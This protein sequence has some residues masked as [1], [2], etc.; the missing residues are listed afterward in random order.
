MEM[1]LTNFEANRRIALTVSSVGDSSVGFY[2]KSE[3]LLSEKDGKTHLSLAGRNEYYGFL[4]RLMEP[5]IT[6]EA[7]KK[8]Q[9]DLLRLKG[10]VEAEPV[11]T[12][13]AE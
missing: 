4:P 12:G 1:L 11:M 7:Q 5:L 3:Y 8:L 9:V 2:E 6:W 10:L 13:G